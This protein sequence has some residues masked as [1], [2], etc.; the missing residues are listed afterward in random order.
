M[1]STWHAYASRDM[2]AAGTEILVTGGH[3]RIRIQTA[4]QISIEMPDRNRL[5][6]I[7]VE[8]IGER[9]LLAIGDAAFV[10]LRVAPEVG[11]FD[12]FKLSDG[13]SRQG[14]IVQ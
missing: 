7:V 13:F 9:V 14:W 4:D 3:E 11:S 2:L 5:S 1:T 6:A 10:R 8:R 12:D